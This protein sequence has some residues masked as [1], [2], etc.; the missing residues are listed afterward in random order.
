MLHYI[1]LYH[2]NYTYSY[3]FSFPLDCELLQERD[4]RN[5][6]PSTL[7]APDKYYSLPSCPLLFHPQLV[8][9]QGRKLRGETASTINLG[10]EAWRRPLNQ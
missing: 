4:I 9:D 10:S 1:I 6:S 7:Q 5:I 3:I 2:I 8:Q